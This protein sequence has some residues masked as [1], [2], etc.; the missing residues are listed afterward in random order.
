MVVIGLFL[1]KNKDRIRLVNLVKGI[2]PGCFEYK[3]NLILKDR[4]KSLSDVDELE[5]VNLRKR[6]KSFNELA[7]MFGIS[8]SGAHGI[9]KRHGRYLNG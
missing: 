5:L 1:Q 4:R 9:C 3:L 7:K 8:K 6:G 2:L